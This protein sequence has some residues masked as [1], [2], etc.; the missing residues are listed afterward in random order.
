MT[1][2]RLQRALAHAGV[3]SRRGAEELIE[4]GVV[5]VDGAVA[6]LGSKVDPDTQT[7]TVRGKRVRLKANR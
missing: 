7:I 3:A 5:K 1:V 6:E 2:M 4:A